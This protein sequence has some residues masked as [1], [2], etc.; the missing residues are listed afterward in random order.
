M[1]IKKEKT[2]KNII[3]I[4]CLVIIV[5][6]FIGL[7]IYYIYYPNLSREVKEACKNSTQSIDYY[8]NGRIEMKELSD[9]LDR[10]AE[11]CENNKSEE[12]DDF[13]ICTNLTTLSTRAYLDYINNEK[14]YIEWEEVRKELK[15]D[16]WIF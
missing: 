11:K 12:L 1:N 7:Y 16:C 10:Y 8:L 2:K 9:L 15:K 13:L 5:L 6:L 3:V 4:I 14:N